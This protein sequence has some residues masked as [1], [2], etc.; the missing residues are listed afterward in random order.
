MSA[1]LEAEYRG[2]ASFREFE[3][4]VDSAHAQLAKLKNQTASPAVGLR[5]S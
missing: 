4:D 1:V 3:R 2:A 5:S